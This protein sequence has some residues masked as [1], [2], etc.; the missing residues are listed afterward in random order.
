MTYHVS[1][2][3]LTLVKIAFSP[4]GISFYTTASVQ[5][6]LYPRGLVLSQQSRLSAVAQQADRDIRSPCVHPLHLFVL[7]DTF[8]GAGCLPAQNVAAGFGRRNNIQTLDLED[9]HPAQ[10]G[11]RS[12]DH[13]GDH[14]HA[15]TRLFR[16]AWFEHLR[17]SRRQVV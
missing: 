3:A 12:S 4:K 1:F 10:E 16:V 6:T 2:P 14:A 7:S 8:P 5:K 11:P 17:A 15:A 9:A 13:S